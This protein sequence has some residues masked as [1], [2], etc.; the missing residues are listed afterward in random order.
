MIVLHDIKMFGKCLGALI[1]SRLAEVGQEVIHDK[2]ALD[3][4][5]LL[6]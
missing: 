1:L 2:D 6:D 5:I 3:G 4:A